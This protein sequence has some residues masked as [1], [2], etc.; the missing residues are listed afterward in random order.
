M[1]L[2][3]L[4]ENVLKW[5]STHQVPHKAQVGYGQEGSQDVE[6]HT[7]QSSHVH[8]YKVHVDGTDH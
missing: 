5:L 2:N 8:Y 3:N 7:V 4:N 1:P 6:Q